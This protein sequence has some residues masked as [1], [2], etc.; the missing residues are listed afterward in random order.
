[1]ES[2]IWRLTGEAMGVETARSKS[3]VAMS[4]GLTEAD[5]T[6]IRRVQEIADKRGWKMSQVAL[7][8][9]R[10]KGCIPIV[11][12]NSPSIQRLDEACAIRDMRLTEGEMK[13]LEEPY[14]PKP[15]GGHV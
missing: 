15:I 8:W 2:S 9:V 10:G 5:E 12:L 7:A 4:G 11:G 3:T 1:M 6:I 14:A 13:Y